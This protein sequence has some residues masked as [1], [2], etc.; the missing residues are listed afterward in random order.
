MPLLAKILLFIFV[1]ILLNIPFGS[2]RNKTRKFSIAWFLSIHLPIPLIIL[3]RRSLFYESI[4]IGSFSLNPLWII[5]FSI[6]AAVAGQLIGKRFNWFGTYQ[7]AD[8]EP[9]ET[10]PVEAIQAESPIAV[11]SVME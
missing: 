8:A 9:S 2:Y 5:P 11:E 6:S 4:H 3:M 7:S 10:E 1:V